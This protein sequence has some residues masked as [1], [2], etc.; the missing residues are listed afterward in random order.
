MSDIASEEERAS[1]PPVISLDPAAYEQASIRPVLAAA[2][3]SVGRA[4]P[5]SQ[6]SDTGYVKGRR[7]D[8]TF[9]LL[10]NPHWVR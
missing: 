6:L 9:E 1:N 10:T 4:T 8:L 3:H 5:R 2:I 7:I